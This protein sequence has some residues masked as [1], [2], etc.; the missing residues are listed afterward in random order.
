MLDCIRKHYNGKVIDYCRKNYARIDESKITF[1]NT[2]LNYRCHWVSYALHYKDPNR[3]D[4]YKCIV[5]DGPYVHCHFIA[6]DKINDVFRD[7]M[8]GVMALCYDI[9]IVDKVDTDVEVINMDNEL[10]DLKKETLELVT[11]K[12]NPIRK[13]C[14]EIH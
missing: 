9:Y 7:D 6:Y 4:V 10:T 5:V 11:H 3:Y 8:Y 2:Y 12:H 14:Y 13:C 1:E